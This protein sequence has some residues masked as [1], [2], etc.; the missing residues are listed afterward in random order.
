MATSKWAMSHF[1][2]EKINQNIIREKLEAQ[3]EK[4]NGKAPNFQDGVRLYI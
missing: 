4:D 2:G 3:L 1:K